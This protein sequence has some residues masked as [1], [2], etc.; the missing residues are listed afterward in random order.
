MA[1]VHGWRPNH[2]KEAD[3]KKK[4]EARKA[5]ELENATKAKERLEATKKR[6]EEERAARLK[7]EAE[8]KAAAAKKIADASSDTQKLVS[9]AVAEATNRLRDEMLAAQS[10]MVPGTLRSARSLLEG[11][12]FQRRMTWGERRAM[13]RIEN[14]ADKLR[15]EISRAF[16]GRESEFV[17]SSLDSLTHI[18]IGARL[19]MM[20]PRAEPADPSEETA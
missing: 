1:A 14:G 3:D 20:R 12:G 17:V 8:D 2:E 13:R 10:E 6:L 7:K 4:E 5:Q 9:A 16:D 15:R 11:G 19:E 18:E